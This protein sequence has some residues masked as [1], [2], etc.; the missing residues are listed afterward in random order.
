MR[1]SITPVPI[2]PRSRGERRSLRTF[3]VV[4]PRPG[5]LAFNLRPYDAF[6]LRLTP[7]NSSDLEAS[8]GEDGTSTDAAS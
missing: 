8:A 5:S 6:Q 3:A 1:S 4:S 2:R 7:F